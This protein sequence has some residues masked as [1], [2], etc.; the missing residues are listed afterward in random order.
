M[1]KIF[2]LTLLGTAFFASAQINL[3][4]KAN[5]LFNTGS[6]SWENIK[7]S[8]VKAYNDSGKN[9][10][11]FNVGL[12]AKIDFP[13]SFFVMPEIYYTTFKSEL[14][15]PDTVTGETIANLEA[16]SNRIDVPV[17]VGYNILGNNLGVFAGPVASYNLS[18][19]NTYADFHE[20]AT[21]QF[22]VGYQFGAQAQ[23]QKIIIN[24]RYEGAF[25][26]DERKFINDAAPA[27]TKE[28]IRYDNRP[29]LFMVGLGYDF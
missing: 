23:F 17:L 2:S 6:P 15:V 25:S 22:T 5:L 16:K 24:A 14:N 18:T 28:Y 11:G 7:G 20:N 19:D 3:S 29:G 21:K 10:V 1:K 12:S 13:T 26:S 4:A 8:A 9:S 27:D